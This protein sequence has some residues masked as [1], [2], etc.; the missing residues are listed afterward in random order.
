LDQTLKRLPIKSDHAQVTIPDFSER[1]RTGVGSLEKDLPAEWRQ[2]GAAQPPQLV[3]VLPG[4]KQ[5]LRQL[6]QEKTFA[7]SCCVLCAFPIADPK[8]V[9]SGHGAN[10]G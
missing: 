3:V 5:N 4:F 1:Q 6:M 8:V 7:T 2:F 10:V 9:R